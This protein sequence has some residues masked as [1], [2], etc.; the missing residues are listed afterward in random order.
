M[1]NLLRILTLFALLCMV[2]GVPS[3][4]ASTGTAAVGKSVA[5][6]I[7]SV[8]GTQPMTFQWNKDGVPIQGATG[9]AIPAWVPAGP[10][11]PNSAFVIAA[12]APADAGT[13]TCT[14][15]NAA[16]STTSDPAVL[17]VLVAPSGAVTGIWS[18][19]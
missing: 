15:T 10:T 3:A 8:D 12:V 5:A 17:T 2:V 6:Y 18:K 19:P 1:K 7:V 9:I 14:V 4:C 11:I 16:G 13:Y